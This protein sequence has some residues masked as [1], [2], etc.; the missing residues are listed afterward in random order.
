MRGLL[1]WSYLANHCSR[2]AESGESRGRV[3]V[4]TSP[5][6][7]NRHPSVGGGPSWY[8][9]RNQRVLA[10]KRESN[11]KDRGGRRPEG[12]LPNGVDGRMLVER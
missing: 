4:G 2:G 6:V 10:K 11:E 9:C 3:G 12:Q 1:A 8:E 7:K 5:Q